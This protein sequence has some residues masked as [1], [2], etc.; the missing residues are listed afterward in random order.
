MAR[1]LNASTDIT[2][3][4]DNPSNEVICSQKAIKTYVDNS[5]QSIRVVSDTN[6]NVIVGTVS[7]AELEEDLSEV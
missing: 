1:I 7:E 2:L 3:G 5:T 4:G 6:G